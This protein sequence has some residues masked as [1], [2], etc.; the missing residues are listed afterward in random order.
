MHLDSFLS[1]LSGD[2]VKYSVW[3]VLYISSCITQTKFGKKKLLNWHGNRNQMIFDFLTSP[4]GLQFEPRMTI[5][6]SFCSPNRFDMQHDHIWKIDPLHG[7]PSAQKSQPWGMTQATEW[8]SRLIC[9][10]PFICEN[11]YKVWYK[12][13]DTESK[14]YLTFWPFPRAPGGGGKNKFAFACPLYVSNSHTKFGW[15]SSIGSGGESITDKRTDGWMG[16]RTDGQTDEGDYNIPF[17][18]L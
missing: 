3:Y 18:F 12:N 5:L 8:K 15:I 14:W 13:H 7:H 11:T 6:F 1:I 9:F 10:V 16:G 2:R 4:Q 17:A